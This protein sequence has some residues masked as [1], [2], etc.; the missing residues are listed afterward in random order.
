MPP[1][2]GMVIVINIVTII[3]VLR[4][5]VVVIIGIVVAMKI[6]DISEQTGEA[7]AA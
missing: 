7:F 5:I 2:I 3:I 6:W 1:V 4:S